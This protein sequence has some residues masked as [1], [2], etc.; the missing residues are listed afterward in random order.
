MRLKQIWE[1]EKKLSLDG[2]R[3]LH[4]GPLW[5]PCSVCSVHVGRDFVSLGP[6][7]DDGIGGQ[8]QTPR[9]P[10]RGCNRRGKSDENASERL[11]CGFRRKNAVSQLFS[12]IRRVYERSGLEHSE[13]ILV[14][15]SD[16]QQAAQFFRV[17][18]AHEKRFFRFPLHFVVAWFRLQ[19][20]YLCNDGH[21]DEFRRQGQL[22][23][24]SASMI[25]GR[26][27]RIMW[28]YSSDAKSCIFHKQIALAVD[29][30]HATVQSNV[31]YID[32]G[33][34]TSVIKERLG[35]TPRTD[36]RPLYK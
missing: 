8:S 18:L 24:F 1:P 7:A 34:S 30:I 35:F 10:I 14:R 17:I 16:V 33:P 25:R 5:S 11:A 2:G 29:R 27:M 4:R 13:N 3:F 12:D 28:F 9:N 19:I 6:S 15:P 32:V 36:Y 23:A 31:Q 22:V 26:T 21:V 20:F